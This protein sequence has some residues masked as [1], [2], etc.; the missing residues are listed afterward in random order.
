M[1]T[2]DGRPRAGAD[3][4]RDSERANDIWRFYVGPDGHWRWQRLSPDRLL[5]SESR[6]G[7]AEYEGCL[8][9]AKEEGYVFLPS[10]DKLARISTR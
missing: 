6:S 10:Q 8:A 9:N 5:I 1:P 2:P 4:S 3:S 7:Y